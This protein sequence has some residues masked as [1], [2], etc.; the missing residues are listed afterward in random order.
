MC[1]AVVLCLLEKFKTFMSVIEMQ[2]VLLHREE[3][4]LDSNYLICSYKNEGC[5]DFEQCWKRNVLLPGLQ[6][7]EIGK[8]NLGWK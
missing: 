6:M 8:F 7:G 1:M 5:A 2:S 4:C 3:K